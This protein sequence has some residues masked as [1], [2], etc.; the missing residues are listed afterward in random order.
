MSKSKEQEQE[1]EQE[2]GEMNLDEFER[3][4][5]TLHFSPSIDD[6]YP[7][8]PSKYPSHVGSC[9]LLVLPAADRKVVTTFLFGLLLNYDTLKSF[10]SSIYR[11]PYLLGRPSF[12]TTPLS[13]V[14]HFYDLCV[15][16]MVHQQR[17]TN[18]IRLD[19]NTDFPNRGPS[20][21]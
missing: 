7:V 10:V 16:G 17:R 2:Q 21:S 20:S 6:L 15:Y 14:V 9:C 3:L 13:F 19:G 8:W 1:Q 18:T 5:F 11:Y 12:V 4:A